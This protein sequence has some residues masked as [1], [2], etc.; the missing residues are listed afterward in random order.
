MKE[1]YTLKYL[2]IL[3]AAEACSEAKKVLKALVPEAFEEPWNH[4]SF[5]VSK[6]FEVGKNY[7]LFA[8]KPIDLRAAYYP[9]GVALN[10]GPD[11]TPGEIQQDGFF[12]VWVH[13]ETAE[14]ICRA[15]KDVLKRKRS[16][17]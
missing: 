6:V 5:G 10:F 13:E 15:I 12:T 16:L 7:K 14:N 9:A 1:E 4:E 3:K 8:S 17:L 2:D 11:T